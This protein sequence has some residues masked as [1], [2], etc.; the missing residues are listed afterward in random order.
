M[1]NT[2]TNLRRQQALDLRLAGATYR[3]IGER[4]GVSP[5][6]AW[7]H[8]QAALQQA[9]QEPAQEVRQIELLRLDRLQT[10]HWP[11]ALGGNTEATDRVLK[12]MDRRSRLLGF[13]QANGNRGQV[14]PGGPPSALDE[15][16]ARRAQRGMA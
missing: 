6:I 9:V 4:L 5:P 14:V 15:I 3:Q 11:Q 7:K 2:R 13:D 1:A 16:R 10:A 12:I 8:T